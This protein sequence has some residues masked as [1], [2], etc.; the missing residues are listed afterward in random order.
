MSELLFGEFIKKLKDNETEFYV[1]HSTNQTVFN[2]KGHYIKISNETSIDKVKNLVKE[3]SSMFKD[4]FYVGAI[5]VYFVS[6]TDL[7]MFRMKHPEIF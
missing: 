5:S 1:I 6:E 7:S 2:A 3:S 4:D